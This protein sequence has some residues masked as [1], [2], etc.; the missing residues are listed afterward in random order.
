MAKEWLS[1]VM[2]DIWNEEETKHP[3]HE[4]TRRIVTISDEHGNELLHV[5]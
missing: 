3:E 1:E 2:R 5:I 4:F